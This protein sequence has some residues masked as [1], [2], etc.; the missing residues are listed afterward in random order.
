[1]G[2]A[3]YLFS[4][5]IRGNWDQIEHFSINIIDRTIPF[6]MSGNRKILIDLRSKAKALVLT[7]CFL[8]PLGVNLAVFGDTSGWQVDVYTQKEPYNGMGLNQSSDAF[9][10]NDIVILYA[11]VSYNMW[12]I[13][14]VP[15]AFHIS[16]PPNPVQ[17]I[18]LVFSAATNSEGV[19]EASFTIPSPEMNPEVIVFGMWKVTAYIENASD[20][21]DFRVGWI[22][23]LVS[24]HAVDQ[25]PPQGGVLEVELSLLNIAM[26]PKNVTLALTLFDSLNSIAGG[27]LVDD[28][29]VDVGVLNFSAM[30]RVSVLAEAGVG[31]VYASVY[32]S[33]DAPISPSL[34]ASFLISLLGDLNFDNKVDMRD[35]SLAGRAFGSFIGHPRWNPKADITGAE[36]LVPDG[37]VD[38]KDL[39]LIARNF[40]KSVV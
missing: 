23:E 3:I 18:S 36:Y 10:P 14:N 4:K 22:V 27:L 35:I 12:P 34:S 32:G 29:V 6:F 5:A 17:N 37:M 25:D 15:V 28:F 9:A 30:L 24:L 38:M 16:G 19:A 20:F 8:F 2:A 33:G 39:S 31:S 40:G 7:M 13:Q 1:M 21:L 26:V 11:N